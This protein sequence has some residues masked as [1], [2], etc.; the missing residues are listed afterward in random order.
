MN[1]DQFQ[2]ENERKI[3]RITIGENLGKGGG[4]LRKGVRSWGE[5]V[6][7]LRGGWV[8]F[9]GAGESYLIW[10]T[11]Y[12]CRVAVFQMGGFVTF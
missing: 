3:K 9:G 1:D 4:R 5:M 12:I 6:C 8:S 2:R 10:E 11:I 7:I